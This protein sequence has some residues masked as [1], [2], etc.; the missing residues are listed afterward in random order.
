MFLS[1]LLNAQALSEKEV[2][3]PGETPVQDTTAGKAV[4]ASQTVEPKRQTSP[5]QPEDPKPAPARNEAPAR[6]PTRQDAASRAP[7]FVP[8]TNEPEAVIAPAR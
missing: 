6:V 3:P 1:V 2:P 8:V 4:G 7:S 5:E